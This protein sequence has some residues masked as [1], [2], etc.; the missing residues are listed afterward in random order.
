MPL[1]EYHCNSCNADVELLVRSTAE[2]P[3]CSECGSQKLEKLLSVA[4]APNMA[5]GSLPVHNTAPPAQ[6]GCGRSQC[7]SGCMFD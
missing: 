4:A 3:E 5:G 1:Y 7:A 6:G 2:I